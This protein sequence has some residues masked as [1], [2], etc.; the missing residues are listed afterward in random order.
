MPTSKANSLASAS[1]P[2]ET[3]NHPVTR[4]L[5]FP[6]R[7]PTRA[8]ICWL[9]LAIF[10]TVS[11]SL[12][13]E[14]RK[15]RVDAETTRAAAS[16]LA[17]AINAAVK[18]SQGDLDRQQHH[19]V[20]AFSTGHF[21]Q[22]PLAAEAARFVASELVDTLLI[23]DDRLSVFAWEMDLWN[24]SEAA[25]IP[26]RVT[27]DSG[28]EKARLRSLWP[29]TPQAG[30]VGGHD[31][32]RAL[33]SIGGRLAGD[34]SA[35]VVML[36]NTAASIS[37]PGHRVIGANHPAYREIVSRWKRVPQV[38][39]S[40]A[41]VVLPYTV[42]GPDGTE[43]MRALD[44]V[45]LVSPSFAGD[46]VGGG[47]RAARLASPRPQAPPPTPPTPVFPVGST[48]IGFNPLW[49]LWLIGA[50]AAIYLLVRLLG[51]PRRQMMLQVNDVSFPLDG[52]AEGEDICHLIGAGYADAGSATVTIPNAPAA[53][54]A[55]I[56]KER[57]IAISIRGESVQLRGVDELQVEN[58]HT[59]K[60][61]GQHR[62]DFRGEVRASPAHPSQ[63]VR[64][65][66]RIEIRPIDTSS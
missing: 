16:T 36:T 6:M 46:P 42:R 3:P 47:S 49:L 18:D 66:V 40:G 44:A 31:T 12:G 64:C 55:R 32:E 22:D 14:E 28:P 27:A 1:K 61:V 52:T 11:P 29:L 8:L 21:S 10:L 24:H 53:R 23:E 19:L 7:L 51:S 35:V 34:R 41:S 60:G 63:P 43:T 20:V 4:S 2:P 30:S 5:G 13:D 57:G 62:L 54:L 38:N 48:R 56:T 45:L 59:V 17:R 9:V 37:A 15:A 58:A 39:K 25:G 33:A 65:T 50:A 26:Q